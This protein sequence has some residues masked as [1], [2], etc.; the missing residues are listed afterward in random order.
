M[1]YVHN[2]AGRNLYTKLDDVLE[3][4]KVND[5]ISH[6]GYENLGKAVD[7]NYATFTQKMMELQSKPQLKSYSK[8]YLWLMT[9]D[10]WIKK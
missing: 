7:N 9:Y 5:Q 6:D 3:I 4:N 8:W 2:T 10:L 1:I